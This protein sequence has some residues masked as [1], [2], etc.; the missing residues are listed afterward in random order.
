MLVRVHATYPVVSMR[1]RHVGRSVSAMASRRK[2]RPWQR[3]SVPGSTAARSGPCRGSRDTAGNHGPCPVSYPYSPFPTRHDG[4][5]ERQGAIPLP[6]TKPR[7]KRRRTTAD[8]PATS[9]RCRTPQGSRCFRYRSIE[10]ECEGTTERIGKERGIDNGIDPA[11]LVPAQPRQPRHA[12][13]KTAQRQ[14]RIHQH[15]TVSRCP[16]F[17]P[18]MMAAIRGAALHA[19]RLFAMPYSACRRNARTPSRPCSLADNAG[20]WINYG[21]TVKRTL[22]GHGRAAPG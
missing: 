16:G 11:F 10:G 19:R 22:P 14:F 3:A 6:K 8:R 18:T 1:A 5:C 9:R 7:C 4:A 2:V 12:H 13:Q 15:S 21:G 20:V 17:R